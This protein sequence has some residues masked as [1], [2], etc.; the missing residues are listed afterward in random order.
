MT[1]NS[2]MKNAS[3]NKFQSFIPIDK[4]FLV[5]REQCV[6]SV[7]NVFPPSGLCFTFNET[8][9]ES[10]LYKSELLVSG[11]ESTYNTVLVLYE[12]L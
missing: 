6:S 4:R 11:N 9:N 3:L 2:Y 5:I 10:L 7:D 12:C 8:R 1:F